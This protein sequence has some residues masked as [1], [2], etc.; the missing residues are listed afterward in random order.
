MVQ[1]VRVTYN[2]ETIEA[3]A[4][5][6]VGR[7]RLSDIIVSHPD[8]SRRHAE[9]GV[10]FDVVEIRDLGSTNGIWSAG[11]RCQS[12]ALN[13]GT[14][15]VRLGPKDNAPYIDITVH[16]PDVV[17]QQ[18]ARAAPNNA[19]PTNA[20]PPEP[21][22]SS[23]PEP[24]QSS[25]PEPPRSNPPSPPPTPSLNVPY[26]PNAGQGTALNASNLAGNLGELSQVFETE[27]N[28]VLIGRSKQCDLVVQDPLVSRRHAELVITGPNT[29]RITDLGG[30][31]G[32]YVNGARITTADIVDGDLVELGRIQLVL[33]NGKLEQHVAYGLPLQANS[34]SVVVNNET[35]ILQNV[36]FTLPAG[37]L[38][39]IVGPSGSGKT[40]LLNA[41]TGRRQADTGNVFLGGRNIYD[42]SDQVSQRIGFVPQDDPV[43]SNLNVEH[44]LVSAAKMRLPQDTSNDEIRQTVQRIA[45]EL[46]LSER[47]PTQ[48]KSLSGGQRK[49]VS[50]GYELVG[51]PQA[52]ILDEPTSGLDPGLERELMNNLR[53]LANR[54]TTTVV[55]THSVQ[56]V[57]LC[58]QVLVL[59]P[60]GRMA[61]VGPPQRA[62]AHFGVPDLASVFT[63][64]SSRP[65]AEWERHFAETSS[66]HRFVDA[67]PV[68]AP[69]GSPK[70]T[71]SFFPDLWT[72]IVRYLRLLGGDK[73]RLIFLIA[74]A[75]VLG[76]L[77]AI[78]L[79]RQ[80]F[81]LAGR[82]AARE[83]LVAMV[84][85]MTL[86]GVLN[87]VREI[88]QDRPVFRREF[89]VGVSSTAFVLSRWIVLTFIVLIQALVLVL[90]G[91]SRQTTGVGP[92]VL[93]GAGF[94][95]LLFAIAG[96]GVASVGLGLVISA[97][98][99]DT[100]KALTM[101]PL[102]IIPAM[103]LSGLVVPTS[104][105]LGVEQISY[106]NPIQWGSSAAASVVDLPGS[107]SCDGAGSRRVNL[108]DGLIGEEE[109]PESDQGNVAASCSNSRWSRTTASQGLNF[110]VQIFGN[111]LLLGIAAFGA[112]RSLTLPLKR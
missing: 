35:P 11:Q 110:G 78:V 106:L 30:D 21:P 97:F 68:Q 75:P 70:R 93:V 62:I 22:Q 56:S 98:V 17:V 49:R 39:A 5:S 43:H 103:L 2:G 66:F 53:E 69:P 36:S 77:L 79:D 105:R 59:A 61:F 51:E 47:L 91:T 42:N 60:G 3:E 111:L 46:G 29:A 45:F 100:P 20:G 109:V 72:L 18:P 63:L 50:V 31:N 74:Q 15:R 34:L 112:R 82:P 28:R 7:E 8:V 40:T 24:P 85:A 33:S 1:Q 9:I 81:E 44:A 54:G 64:L 14:T 58:D 32:T 26:D 107:E 101:F 84:L 83:Y 104:G 4:G 67:A 13:Q 90:L 88:V 65:N 108:P 102:V 80:A 23:R 6:V 12:I 86:I 48:V 10:T 16:Q 94:M 55:V 38:T 87:S 37:S 25:P 92:G 99:N 73:R 95:E 57:E 52:L 41:L 71:R 89:A 76:L 96:I 27:A 19:A